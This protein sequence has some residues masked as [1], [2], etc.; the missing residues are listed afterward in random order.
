MFLE[1]VK[2]NVVEYILSSNDR[3]PI[4]YVRYETDKDST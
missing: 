3:V 2:S 1:G 4:I